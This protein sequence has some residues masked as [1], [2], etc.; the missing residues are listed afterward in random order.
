MN[1]IEIEA[2]V[3]FGPLWGEAIVGMLIGVEEDDDGEIVADVIT[4][5]EMFARALATE[6]FGLLEEALRGAPT[7]LDP[8][9]PVRMRL[10]LRESVAIYLSQQVDEVGVAVARA[11]TEEQNLSSVVGQSEAW[12]LMTA[13]QP[14]AIPG[15]PDA[16]AEVGFA[17]VWDRSIVE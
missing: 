1:V 16:F 3:A 7:E 11:L 13:T 2:P 15:D 14:E 10:R 8:E 17:T 6:S 12:L 4:P 9:Q 5:P